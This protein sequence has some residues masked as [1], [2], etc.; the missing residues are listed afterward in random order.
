[1]HMS[2]KSSVGWSNGK[3]TSLLSVCCAVGGCGWHTLC[4]C[5][6]SGRG[7]GSPEGSTEN[8]AYQT[9]VS[10]TPTQEQTE[11]KMVSIT[12]KHSEI[13]FGKVWDAAL[14]DSWIENRSLRLKRSMIKNLSQSPL[15]SVGQHTHVQTY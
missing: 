1:M 15:S 10:R 4:S 8:P 14:L 7:G 3:A 11:R 2:V 13:P 6:R 9:A 5:G 12:Q